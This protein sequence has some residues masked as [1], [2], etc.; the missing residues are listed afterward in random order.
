MEP[1]GRS[2]T[3]SAAGAGRTGGP[4]PVTPLYKRLPHGPHRMARDE[5]IL[6]QRA[7]IHGAMIE[8]VAER[9][10]EGTSVKQVIGLAGV[11]RRSFYEQFANKQES[12]LATFDLLV[13]QTARRALRA[14]T[15]EAGGLEKRLRASFREL[16]M[17]TRED[18]KPAQLVL[19]E[20]Q[21]A[22]QAG[23]LRVCKSMATCEQ[24]LSRTFVEAADATPLPAPITRGIAGGLHGAVAQ[25]IRA[26]TIEHRHDLADELLRW[27]L[28]FQTPAA[29]QMA[30]RL[31]SRLTE[32]MRRISCASA[33]ATSVGSPCIEDEHQRLLQTM[34]RLAG[35]YEY[36]EVTAPQI[37]DEANVSIDTFLD[38]FPDRDECF[39]EALAMVGDDLLAVTASPDLAGGDWTGAVR[40]AV[41]RLLCHL[42][43]RPLYART[44]AQSAF[45][46]GSEA[47][48]RDLELARKIAVLLTAGAPSA[49]PQTLTVE[50]IAGALWHTIR[51]Q[52]V[53]ERVQMLGALSDYLS[54][55]VMAPFIGAD[56]AFEI[57]AEDEPAQ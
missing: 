19:V 4:S 22:G 17:S 31:A 53:A 14:Y 2:A 48:T 47:V 46:A 26:G 29:T 7:R 56:A 45:F 9:G 25:V 52:V 39:M 10:Y 8:A 23:M 43:D 20:A 44:I 34:L 5:V 40:R 30:T 18:P 35:T 33:H 57:L 55:V 54:Y 11:S 1:G 28:Q 13:H 15:T 21:T 51:C 3:Q 37:A 42:A 36:R 24:M 32:R 12:F 38:H 50:G 49:A 6:H 27:T 41:K 16:H